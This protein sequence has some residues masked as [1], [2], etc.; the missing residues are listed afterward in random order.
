M[1]KQKFSRLKK[2]CPLLFV[3]VA[4]YQTVC[5]MHTEYDARYKETYFNEL[6]PITDK[7]FEL[8]NLIENLER[9]FKRDFDADLAEVVQFLEHTNTPT[10]RAKFANKQI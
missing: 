7:L 4:Q 10:F 6:R 5:K 9:E 1:T 2:N 8:E 3:F